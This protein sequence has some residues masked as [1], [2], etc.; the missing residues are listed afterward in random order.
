MR[1]LYTQLSRKWL[2]E[3]YVTGWGYSLN[4][5][6]AHC[7]QHMASCNSDIRYLIRAYKNVRLRFYYVHSSWVLSDI[8]NVIAN[9][10]RVV[11]STAV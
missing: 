11:L 3:K 4:G 7:R 8:S 2:D 9:D 10:S 6:P 5:M 1:P